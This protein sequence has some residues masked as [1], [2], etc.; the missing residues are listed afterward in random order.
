MPVKVT[1]QL[2]VKDDLEMTVTA[3]MTVAQWARICGMIENT[4]AAPN[5]SYYAPLDELKG[6]IRMAISNIRRREEIR[7]EDKPAESMRA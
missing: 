5:N 4:W 7:L 3:T 6:A 2:E 1:A